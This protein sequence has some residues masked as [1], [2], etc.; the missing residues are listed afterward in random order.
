MFWVVDKIYFFGFIHDMKKPF[1]ISAVSQ[2]TKDS[3]CSLT[4]SKQYKHWVKLCLFGFFL[5]KEKL[6]EVQITEW[7][8]LLGCSHLEDCC[9]TFLFNIDSCWNKVDCKALFSK[10]LPA[11]TTGISQ[12]IWRLREHFAWIFQSLIMFAGLP[13]ED[14]SDEVTHV[15]ILTTHIGSSKQKWKHFIEEVSV[16]MCLYPLFLCTRKEISC[17]SSEARTGRKLFLELKRWKENFPI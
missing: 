12:D 2:N 14:A 17:I 3:K 4:T 11:V 15:K 10:L 8:Q 13:E 5:C 6:P 1:S 9:C 16:E 7:I